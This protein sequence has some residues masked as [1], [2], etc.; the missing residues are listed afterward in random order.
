VVP[1][2]IEAGTF[3]IAGIAT[4]GDVTASNV[5]PALLPNFLEKL[6]EMGADIETTDTSIRAKANGRLKAA[7]FSTQP[8]PGFPTDLQ[9]QMMALMCVAEGTSVI[10]ELVFENRFMQAAELSRMG[11]DIDIDGNTAVIRGVE[12]LSGAPIM[13]SDLRASAALIIAGLMADHGETVISRVYH[14]DRGYERIEERL[15][16]L[17]AQIERTREV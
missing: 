3:L 5:S 16:A 14:I 1:D 15:A 9:A 10:R 12:K 8:F 7:D 13:A 2:R 17:G 4:G 11:A 6:I